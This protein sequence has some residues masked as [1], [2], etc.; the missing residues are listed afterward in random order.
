[1][2]NVDERWSIDEVYTIRLRPRQKFRF[3]LTVPDNSRKRGGSIPDVV[4]R[5]SIKSRDSRAD[6]SR[7]EIVTGKRNPLY[8]DLYPYP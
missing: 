4:R 3:T 1:M 8:Q 2:M 6:S 7:N 5:R